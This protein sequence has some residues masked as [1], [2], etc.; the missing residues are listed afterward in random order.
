MF[1]SN[2]VAIGLVF[3]LALVASGCSWFG[4]DGNAASASPT[5]EPPKSE[6]P[7]ETKEPETFQADFI[8][9]AAGT[10]TRVRYARKGTNWRV[11]TFTGDAA[12]RSIIGTDR[13]THLDHRTKTYTEPPSGGGPADRPVFVNDLTQML[14][15]RKDRAKYE[16]LSMSGPLE[17]YRVTVDGSSTPFIVAYDPALKMV[18]RQEPETPSPGGFVFELRAVTLEVSDDA[19]KIPTGYRKAAWAEFAATR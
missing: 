13:K 11:D 9:I 2:R 14:L 10:E 12:S 1:L 16:K 18:V 15:N 7:F 8:T 6:R 5:I 19:F 3:L 4:D 17:R